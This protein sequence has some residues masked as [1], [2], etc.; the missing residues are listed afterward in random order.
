MTS[1]SPFL[2]FFPLLF[3]LTL[4]REVGKWGV[5]EGS[6][7]HKQDWML[8]LQFFFNLSFVFVLMTCIFLFVCMRERDDGSVHTSTHVCICVDPHIQS[9]MLIIR[10]AACF[11]AP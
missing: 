7:A 10:K 3:S 8:L 9:V 11:H 2:L 6:F 4:L 5:G 1:F